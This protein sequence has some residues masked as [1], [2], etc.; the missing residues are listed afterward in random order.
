MS[1]SPQKSGTKLWLRSGGLLGLAACGIC[2]H[3]HSHRTLVEREEADRRRVAALRGKVEDTHQAISE[4]AA[5]EHEANEARAGLD[6][7]TQERSAGPAVVWFPEWLRAQL[8]RFGIVEAQI[9]LNAERPQP[10]VAGFK[11]ISWNVSLPPQN[12]MRSLT[13]VLLAVKEIDQR[14]RFVTVL[15]CS[16]HSSVEE[17]H[18]PAG[19]FNVEALIRE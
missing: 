19:G 17:P 14:E 2:F 13:S 16:F 8:R 3:V 12:G 6:R 5:I 11:R 9:R 7:W 15:D 18:W 10:G 4:I 1:V